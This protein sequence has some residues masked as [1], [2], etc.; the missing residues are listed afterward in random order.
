MKQPIKKSKTGNKPI[1]Q[2]K[3][4]DSVKKKRS[5]PKYGTSKLEEDFASQFLKKLGVEYQYQFEAKD[6]GR[7]YDFYLPK[8]NLIIEINGDFWHGNPELYKEEEQQ[9]GHQ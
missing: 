9:P 3:A 7:F 1:K 8:H 6:I 4:K 5:H 2:S